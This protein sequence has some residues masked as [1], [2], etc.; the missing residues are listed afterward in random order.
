MQQHFRGYRFESLPG[1]M[2]TILTS[3]P[4]VSLLSLRTGHIIP[5]RYTL[6]PNNSM[7]H[8]VGYWQRLQMALVRERTIPTERSPLVSEINIAIAK[9]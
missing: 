6:P 8:S 3:F 7:L 4:W 5:I 2:P 1:G 9:R